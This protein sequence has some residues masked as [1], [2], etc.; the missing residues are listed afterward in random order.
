VTDDSDTVSI[1]D[2]A[3]VAKLEHAGCLVRAFRCDRPLAP[4]ERICFRRATEIVI[5]RGDKNVA[6]NGG[7]LDIQVAD[8]RMSTVHARLRVGVRTTIEDAGSKNGTLV[9]GHPCTKQELSDGDVVETGHTF[10]VYRASVAQE[11]GREPIAVAHDPTGDG[12]ALV[13]FLPSL[14]QQLDRLLRVAPSDLPVV[15]LGET[16]TGK[17]VVARALHRL[18]GRSG[19]FIAVNCGAIP[20]TLIESELFGVKKGAFSGATEDRPGLI[21]AA[22]RGTLFLD[23]IGELPPP[24]QIALLR[25]LQESEVVPIGGVRPIEVDARLVT[26]THRPLEQLVERT[27]FRSD[28][29]AR[30]T[31]LTVR[32]PPLR[33]RREDLGLIIASVLARAAPA[34]ERVSMTRTAARVLFSHPFSRNIR[35]LD[36]ALRLAVTIAPPEDGRLEIDLEDL[37]ETMQTIEGE[38]APAPEIETPDDDET[39]RAVLLQ[40]LEQH[41]GRIAAV[42]RAMGKARMQIH[43]WIQRYEIDLESYRKLETP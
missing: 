29:Y 15:I 12:L 28:L 4:P 1:H 40:L 30:L 9:N 39:R 14:A 7:I 38:P 8:D 6:A 34:P 19:A 35:E 20:G 25:V 27:S 21:R 11:L 41:Q 36:K 3:R 32:L 33:E 5:G 24:A 42:A 31:G 26:A 13:T 23:E 43:R 16:G 22:D 37:P 18:S 17:E 2:G 10:F